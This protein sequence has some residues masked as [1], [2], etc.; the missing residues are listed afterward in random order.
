MQ[1]RKVAEAT[2]PTEYGEFRILGYE[3]AGAA[4]T[5]R[6]AES[7]LALVMGSPEAGVPTLVRIHSQCL[8]G[9]TF[10]SARCDCGA[11][12]DLALRRIAEAGCGI[13]IYQLAEGR[14]I[15]LM[16]K[17][18]AYEIQDRG[19]DTVEA[20]HQLGFGADERDYQ[21]PA[22]VLG[23]LGVGRIR[24]MSNNPEKIRALEDAGFRAVERVPLEIPPSDRSA[25]YLR[26]KKDKL[27]HLLSGV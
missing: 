11:Q 20:N 10:R 12:L 25:G 15:G 19:R 14:G 27:G 21:L 13:L 4:E 22:A 16:N 9:D 24:L 8:T 23:A 7:L 1:P 2:L 5:D 17:L 6:S 18:L 26:T 3:A